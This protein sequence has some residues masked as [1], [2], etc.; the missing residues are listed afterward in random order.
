MPDAYTNFQQGF[1]LLQMLL[2]QLDQSLFST[3][4]DGLHPFEKHLYQMVTGLDLCLVEQTH[5]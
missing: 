3:I 5:Q 4:V 1:G 2:A